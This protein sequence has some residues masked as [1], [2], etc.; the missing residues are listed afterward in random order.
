MGHLVKLEMEKIRRC[1]CSSQVA[2]ICVC[3]CC[4]PC[5]HSM[6]GF[7]LHIWKKKLQRLLT[8]IQ[9]CTIP[10]IEL[11]SEKPW[12]S[13]QK[14]QR[15]K[16]ENFRNYGNF[17][18]TKCWKY[19]QFSAFSTLGPSSRSVTTSSPFLRNSP[20]NYKSWFRKRL[21]TVEFAY[22]GDAGRQG[23]TFTMDEL[24]NNQ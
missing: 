11:A 18:A 6:E 21:P 20:G 14:N 13:V 4:H 5:T 16:F 2:V 17:M 3:D 19:G 10:V 22:S 8:K 24:S 15:T 1:F 9:C 23:S 12:L 7:R